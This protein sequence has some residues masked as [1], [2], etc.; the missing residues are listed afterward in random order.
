[1]EQSKQEYIDARILARRD[2]EAA[3]IQACGE[4]WEEMQRTG[5]Y[6]IATAHVPNGGG[7]AKIEWTYP[8]RTM[9][10]GVEP[11]GY[12]ERV[13][14]IK[15]LKDLIISGINRIY[16]ETLVAR[17]GDK[18]VLVTNHCGDSILVNTRLDAAENQR[19][20]MVKQLEQWCVDE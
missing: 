8:N 16:G 10:E 9:P 13:S 18:E 20:A 19:K 11:F 4:K 14:D 15:L 5:P 7:A 2:G 6:I 12:V 3:Y 1:M 17:A